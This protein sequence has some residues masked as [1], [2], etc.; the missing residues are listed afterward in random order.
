MNFTTFDYP[1][2]SLYK[3]ESLEDTI[4]D[5]LK[6]KK[7]QIYYSSTFLSSEI[8]NKSFNVKKEKKKN[9]LNSINSINFLKKSK[10]FSSRFSKVNKSGMFK[11]KFYDDSRKKVSDSQFKFDNIQLNQKT[12]ITHLSPNRSLSEFK[13][14]FE[15]SLNYEDFFKKFKKSLTKF[16]IG[17]FFIQEDKDTRKNSKY[18]ALKLK[19]KRKKR[20]PRIPKQKKY[21]QKFI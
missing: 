4:K 20:K 15:P 16:C 21:T 11:V 6:D 19:N 2:F 1:I 5:F 12:M 3:T 14:F 9:S 8:S 7:M 18:L 17:S 13:P 10:S